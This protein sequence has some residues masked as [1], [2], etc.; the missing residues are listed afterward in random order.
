LHGGNVH[1]DLELPVVNHHQGEEGH[2]ATQHIVEVVHVVDS[3]VG[4]VCEY[5]QIL[6]DNTSKHGHANEC[7]NE[8]NDHDDCYQLENGVHQVLQGFNDDSADLEL[9]HQVDQL[10]KSD[11]ND[12][13]KESDCSRG[14]IRCFWLVLSV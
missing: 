14:S 10:E 6:S 4:I 9:V 8:V 3:V 12:E 5:L 7:E 2:K 1:V 13:F 11:E